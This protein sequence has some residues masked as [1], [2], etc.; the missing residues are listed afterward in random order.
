MRMSPKVSDGL[1][2][3]MW[4][5]TPVNAGFQLS[6]NIAGACSTKHTDIS[7]IWEYTICSL[8]P[9]VVELQR[10]MVRQ[11][12]LL[13]QPDSTLALMAVFLTSDCMTWAISRGNN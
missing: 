11:D 4:C 2:I 9:V 3:C 8:S 6:Y 7:F 1:I 12:I 10:D 13:C 5:T